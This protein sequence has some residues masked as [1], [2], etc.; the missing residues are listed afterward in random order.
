VLHA[1]SILLDFIILIVFGKTVQSYENPH[2]AV[3]FQPRVTS[4]LTQNILLNTR[5]SKTINLCTFLNVID[6]ASHPH[7]V[8]TKLQAR[9]F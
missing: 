6:Q 7:K 5:L 8:T 9:V 2:H 3:S 4:L 1:P